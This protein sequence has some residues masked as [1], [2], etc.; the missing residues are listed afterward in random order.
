MADQENNKNEDLDNLEP[1]LDEDTFSL[2]LDD[3]D[4]GDDDL[5]SSPGLEP[6]TLEDITNFEDE[7]DHSISDLVVS[8]SDD[9]DDDL[10]DIDLDSDLNLLGEE[11]PILHDDDIHS[12]FGLLDEDEADSH[13]KVSSAEED[14]LELEFDD[15]VIDLD[16]EI[17]AILNGEDGIL[18]QRKSEEISSDKD[19]E[20]SGSDFGVEEEDGPIALSMEELENIAG[21][22]EEEEEAPSSFDQESDDTVGLSDEYELESDLSDFVEP[23]S[24]EEEASS[25]EEEHSIDDEHFGVDLDLD[26]SEVDTSLSFG[27]EGELELDLEEDAP[28]KKDSSFTPLRDPEEEELFGSAKEDENLT[29][30]DDELGDI[31]GAGGEASL[32]E[33]LGSENDF[34]ESEEASSSEEEETPS[35]DTEEEDDGPITLSLEELDHI[36]EDDDTELN[37]LEDEPEDETITLSPDELGSIIGEDE[38]EEESALETIDFEEAEASSGLEG[39]YEETQKQDLL[40]DEFEDDG[41]IAL[42]MEELES[43]AEDAEEAPDEELVDSLD[44]APLPYEEE[45]AAAGGASLPENDFLEEDLEDESIALSLEELE[46]ITAEEDDQPTEDSFDLVEL[47]ED[48]D[49]ITDITDSLELDTEVEEPEKAVET[50]SGDHIDDLLGESLPG[51]GLEDIGEL[52]EEEN[53][54][55]GKGFQDSLED[56]P[57]IELTLGDIPDLVETE[58][59]EAAS[60]APVSHQNRQP[61]LG[62]DDSET[63]EIDLDEYAPEGKLSPIEELRSAASAPVI[64][65]AKPSSA[66]DEESL[67]DANGAELSVADRKKVLG[68]LDNLLGNLP[69]DVIKEFSKS[70]YFDLYKK[71][72]KE[73]EL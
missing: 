17:D 1:I 49:P 47:E 63:I 39:E 19:L 33:S 25:E 11:D 15:D 35:F 14:D 52:P 16:K 60:S 3:F 53:S 73:L 37:I 66:L 58:E 64:E 51:D 36:S 69:D 41:P 27:S 5:E 24:D 45:N 18:S 2:D 26:D 12:D 28:E 34:F 46:N 44:R 43:I 67:V 20:S 23:V 29:L 7:D 32:E 10:L 68:Y 42:S 70:Q 55:A 31:L 62:S 22:S 4:L 48:A 38:S 54:A 9:S 6:P 57:E 30:S 65:E 50:V 13:S 59:E 61:T 72:M 71:L 21:L 8:T 56:E 40:S